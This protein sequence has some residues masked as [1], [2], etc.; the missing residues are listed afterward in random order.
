MMERLE[1]PRP[2]SSPSTPPPPPRAAYDAPDPGWT[3]ANG[4]WL[5]S[6]A[7]GPSGGSEHYSNTLN[8]SASFTFNGS[9]FHLL[10]SSDSNRA[11]VQ[12]SVDGS[13]VTTFS[14]NGSHLYQQNYTSPV[15]PTVSHPVQLKNFRGSG[16]Y[17]PSDV[18]K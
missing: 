16:A 5:T 11:N 3:F 2:T 6:S 9:G 8:A 15:F 10:Y 13:V 14:Q 4:T 1:Q 17:M 12:V 7:S 18:L